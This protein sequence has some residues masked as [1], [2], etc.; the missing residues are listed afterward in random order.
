MFD[1]VSRLRLEADSHDRPVASAMV[2]YEGEAMYFRE[3]VLAVGRAE[4]WMNAVVEGMRVANRYATKKAIFDYGKLRR[5][6]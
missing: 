3:A 4:V 5:P 2:S 6:R 1:N